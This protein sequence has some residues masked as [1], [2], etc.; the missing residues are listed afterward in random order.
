MRNLRW[1]LYCLVVTCILL[2]SCSKDI[3]STSGVSENTALPEPEKT[4]PYLSTDDFE[5]I[6]EHGVLR[7]IAPRFDGADALPRGGISIQ[8]YQQLA[9]KF[10]AFHKLDV[11][12]VFVDSFDSLIPSLLAGEGDLVITN[13]TVTKARQQAVKFSRSVA[14]ISEHVISKKDHKIDSWQ[15]LSET[16][17]T[18]PHGTAYI[19]TLNAKKA[20]NKDINITIQ[21]VSGEVSDSDLLSGVAAGQYQTTIIDSDIARKLLPAYP[22]LAMGFEVNKHRPIAWPVRKNNPVLLRALNEFLVSHH[23]KTSSQKNALRDWQ[24]IKTS[25][26][27]RMLTLNNP[28]SYFMWRGELMGFDY[29][30]VRKFADTHQLHLSVIIKDSIPELFSALHAGEGDVIAAS[31]THSPERESKG[32]SFTRPYLKVTEQ[33]VGREGGPKIESLEQLS[34]FKVGLNPA[35]VFYSRMLDQVKDIED[36]EIVKVEHA[37]TEELLGRL[38]NQEFDFTVADSHLV[39]LEKSY[40]QNVVANL[41]LTRESPIAMVVRDGKNELLNE[42]NQYIQKEYRGLFYN[43][44]YNK[45]FKNQKKIARYQNERIKGDKLS[46]YDDLVKKYAGNYDMDWRL[47]VSQIYQESKFNPKAKSFAGAV[48]LMQVMPRTAREFGFDNLQIPENGVAAGTAY[49][50]WLEERFPGEL[51]FQERIYFTLAAYNAGTGHVRDARR[52]AKQLGFDPNKW[53]GHVDQAMLK[54]SQPQYYKQSRF[55]YVRGREPVTYVR[56]I[57]DR[58]LGYLSAGI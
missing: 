49:M 25:G 58:Y 41:D 16:S 19:E 17:I 3:E 42:L 55:G 15:A 26:R 28:A 54:L 45:Y 2:V 52:L 40:H 57:R 10:A 1:L 24:A 51:D 13:M 23:V 9:E 14:R 50:N 27:L 12:W 33:I 22:E 29:E 36:V 18:L 21:E 39:A 32:L 6:R 34:G 47:L 46:S 38:A 11:Q 48:G 37:T 5:H 43:I 35:T 4:E 53:F 20:K 56:N 7:L 8:V 30:L 44:V 31:I